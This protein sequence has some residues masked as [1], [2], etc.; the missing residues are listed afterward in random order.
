MKKSNIM[1]KRFFVEILKEICA[2]EGF[3][4]DI[5]SHE[6]LCKITNPKTGK[7]TWTVGY[8]FNLNSG[9][10]YMTLHDKVNTSTVLKDSGVSSVEHFLITAEFY[11]RNLGI[12]KTWVDELEDIVGQINVNNQNSKIVVKEATSTQGEQVYL[13]S[14]KED[15]FNVVELL[16]KKTS[17]AVCKYYE[18]KYE[19]RFYILDGEILF[20][21]R[22]TK[23]RNSWKHNLSQGASPELLLKKEIDTKYS[24]MK[25]LVLKGNYT[26]GIRCAAVDVLETDEGYKILEVNSG[27][28]MDKFAAT[29]DEYKKVAKEATRKMLLSSLISK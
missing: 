26:L 18:S 21:Y 23:N 5:Y 29:S 14:T 12:E 17:V 24:D 11:R 19:Y 2:E 15:V 10:A 13:C 1:R 7:H 20:A 27:I 25:V 9:V 16:Q 6:W 8:N 4:L 3:R 22:K 28:A